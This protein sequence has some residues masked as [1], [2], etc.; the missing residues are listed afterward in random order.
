MAARES[1]TEAAHSFD[2][3]VLVEVVSDDP[4]RAEWS[5]RQPMLAAA[6]D[7]LAINDVVYAELAVRYDTIEALEA[8]IRDAG[9]ISA[10][11]APPY[12]SPGSHFSDI[13]PSVACE[14]G[15]WS[16]FFIGAHAVIAEVALI[17]RDARRY[18]AYFPESG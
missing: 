16:D 7:E 1:R 5:E 12:S 10:A 18:R 4:A 2:T 11:R 8:M 9:L 3:N 13:V 17:S 14:P 6:R 15:C